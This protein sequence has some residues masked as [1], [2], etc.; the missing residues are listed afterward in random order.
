[1]SLT[2]VPV[3]LWC[4][5][6]AGERW[7]LVAAALTLALPGLLYCGMIMTE[8]AFL[9]V[10]VLAAW[11]MAAALERPRGATGTARRCGRP[12]VRDAAPGARAPARARDRARGRGAPRSRR[13]QGAAVLAGRSRVSA[14]SR[15]AGPCRLHAGGRWSEAAGLLRGGHE[16]DWDRSRS[17]ASSPTTLARPR[18][19][20]GAL[21][22]LCSSCSRGDAAQVDISPAVRAH[23]ATALAIVDLARGRGRCVR[24]RARRPPG[25]AR[26]ARAAPVLFLSL[27]IWLDRGAGDRGRAIARRR[28]RRAARARPAVASVLACRSRCRTRSRSCPFFKLDRAQPRLEPAPLVARDRGGALALALSCCCRGGCWSCSR[29]SPSG[30]WRRHSVYASREVAERA[31]VRPAIPARRAAR[32]GGRG[33]RRA[34]SASSTRASCTANGVY[35]QLFWNREHLAGLLPL[36][37]PRC[38]ADPA[39]GGH[40]DGRG[41][42]SLGAAAGACPSATWSAPTTRS[43]HG[44]STSRARSSTGSSRRGSSCGGSTG[45]MRLTLDARPGVRPDGDMHEPGRMVANECPGGYFRMTLIA[46]AQPDRL[47][48][49]QRRAV[50]SAL[51]VGRGHR[52][53][54]TSRRCPSRVPDVHARSAAATACSARP[55]FEFLRP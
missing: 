8:V 7:A 46:E 14:C 2:A 44:A 24:V 4:R 16:R 33:R 11:A 10:L 52:S 23:V 32:L 47:A 43:V 29:R 9:P 39:G 36:G 42:L 13:A 1:M 37:R 28:A 18:A 38:P 12:R 50:R 6:L 27:G 22:C 45:E 30:R 5:R 34:A 49:R 41:L 40:V 21:P 25:R 26:S 19:P 48:A 3:F 17:R 55:S 15:P 53:R 31:R 35:Q 54:R 51:H 20:D